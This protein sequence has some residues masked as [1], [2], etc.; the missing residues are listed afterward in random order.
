M[1][2]VLCVWEIWV[3]P[4]AINDRKVSLKMGGESAQRDGAYS[5]LNESG[6][7]WAACL[8]ARVRT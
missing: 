1:Y 4:E 5:R 3:N 8:R 6:P 7:Q 2:G